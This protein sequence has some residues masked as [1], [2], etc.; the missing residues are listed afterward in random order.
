MLPVLDNHDERIRYYELLLEGDIRGVRE[1]PLP[2]GYAFA[3]YRPGDRDAWIGIE[4]SAKEFAGYEEGLAA[5]ERFYGGH[6]DLL[7][8]RMCFVVDAAGE[9]VATATAYHDITGRDTSGAGWLHWVAVRREE[10][11]RGLSKPLIAHVL[12]RMRELGY[13]RAKIPTQT[14]TWVAC[15][16]YLDLGFRP[17]PANAVHS[18]DGWRIIRRLTGHPALAEFDPADDGEILTGDGLR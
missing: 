3:W 15:K 17:I 2:A 10:Q 4:R 1:T 7:P 11:G 14:T 6:E 18:R 12:A 16:V 8:A 9:K 5:W 13:T